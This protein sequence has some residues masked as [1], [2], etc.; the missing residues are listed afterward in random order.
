MAVDFSSVLPDVAA[1]AVVT[2]CDLYLFP[3]LGRRISPR[4]IKALT[5]GA[6]VRLGS[7]QREDEDNF[8]V[9]EGRLSLG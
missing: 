1:R 4:A 2:R 7:P 5:K 9:C 8:V 6:G 3:E